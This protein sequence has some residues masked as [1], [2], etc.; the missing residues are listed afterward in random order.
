[1]SLFRDGIGG[2]LFVVSR[3]VMN[4]VFANGHTYTKQQ[5]ASPV[6]RELAAGKRMNHRSVV[7]ILDYGMTQD[8]P[9]FVMEMVDG[10]SL[11]S[12][13]SA[14]RRGFMGSDP[15]LPDVIEAVQ[16]GKRGD[17]E[18]RSIPVN[19]SLTIL[20]DVM[21]GIEHAHDLGLCI[22]ILSLG[23]VMPDQMAVRWLSTLDWQ[24]S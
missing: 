21:K 22:A 15:T 1:M 5:S 9:W 13:F 3:E 19:Q 24:K 12:V 16:A 18:R 6:L 4:A 10:V 7:R 23:N 11:E 20:I 2:K 14:N 8:R 17:G